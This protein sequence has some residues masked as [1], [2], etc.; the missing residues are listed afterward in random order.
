MAFKDY[1][2]DIANARK[3]KKAEDN[4]S[5]ASTSGFKDYSSE[6][7]RYHLSNTI[8]FDTFQTDLTSLSKTLGNIY[9]GWQNRDTMK[10]TLSSVQSMYDRL[11]KY[12]EYQ[13]KYGGTD[14]SELQ[15][16]YKSV[17][18]DWDALSNEYGR[19]KDASAYTKEKTKL[20]ELS[21]MTSKDIEPYLKDKKNK[22][23]Y[24]SS[25]GENILW[26]DLYDSAYL[27]EFT[28]EIKSNP[29]FLD[30]S[31]YK[32][33]D[34]KYEKT[35]NGY[36]VI[37]DEAAHTY[38][39]INGDEEAKGYELNVDTNMF[40]TSDS[41][42]NAYFTEDEKRIFN[43]IWETQGQEKA[44][45][46]V[47]LLDPEL[48]Q[49]RVDAERIFDAQ[50]AKESPIGSS[51]ATVIANVGNNAMALPFLAMDYAD[52]GSIDENSSLYSGR[53]AVNT[54]RGT[55]E[56]DIDN[57][58]GKFFYRHGM[59][60][61]DN[62]AAMAV[63][64][65]G[66]LGV[67]SS[68]IQKGIMS[69]GAVVDTVLD[70][71]S[72]GLSDEKALGLGMI[73][74]AAEWYFESKSFDALFD[75]KTLTESGWKYF[76]NNIKTELVGEL[77]TELTNDISDVLISQDFSKWKTDINSYIASGMTEKEALNKAFKEAGIRYLDV[78]AGTLFS[79]GVISGTPAVAGSVAQ[80]S[81]NKNMGQSIKS[82]ERVSDM[83]DLASNPEI[84]TAYEAYTRYANKG[85]NAENIKDAQLGSLY[86]RAKADAV[87]TLK[88]KK[89][90]AE[91]KTGAKQTLARLS[92][93][94]TENTV[95][96]E[97]KK[98]NVGEETKATKSG[99]AID[100]KD[101]KI[102]GDDASFVTEKGNISVEDATLTQKDA[103]FVVLARGIAQTDGEDAANLFVSQYDGKMDVHEYANS[104]NLTMAY[105]KNNFT[106]RTILNKKGKLSTEAVNA[107]Y[108]QTRI[109][110]D[111]ARQET[112]KKLNKAMADKMTYQ[113]FIDD[114][115]IDYEN[116]SA[117]GKVNWKD[118]DTRQKQAVTFIKGFAQASGMNLVLTHNPKSKVGG[119]YTVSGNTITIDIAKYNDYAGVLRET[120][121]PTMSHETTHWMKEKSP[122]LWRHLNEIVFTTLTEHYNSNTEQALKDKR[123]LLN[124]LGEKYS[125]DSLKERTITEKDL[126]K[127]EIIRAGKSE[128]V[129]REE[130]I[131]RACEDMLKM[132][133]QGRKIFKSLSESEQ[134][135]LYEK[136]KGIITDLINWVNDLLNS[137]ESTSTEARIMREYKEE[138][139]KASKI[140][141]EMLKK[142]IEANQSLEKSG[143][144]KH[145]S[146]DGGVLLQ[147]RS[148]NGN[149]VVW[150]EENILK[151][152]KGQ[153]VHQFIADF[154]AE[155]IGDVYTLIESGQKVYI[156][157][158]LPGEYTQSQYT[159]KV[160]AKNP[161]IIKAKNKATANIKEIIEIAT[162]R[163]WEKTEHPENKDAKYGM[164][165]Y[166]TWFG[167]PVYD[168]KGNTVRANI[169]KAE[170]VIRN[171][172][173]GRKYLYD[174]VDIKKDT[175]SSDWMSKKISSAA[176]F[177]AGQKNNVSNYSIPNP[178]EKV[179]TKITN[180]ELQ[181][182]QNVGLQ[183]DSET[184][185]VAP[186]VL[187]SER[188]WNESQYVQDRETAINAIVKA[189][190]VSKKD[191]ARYVDN[192]NSIARMIADDRA[193]L[194]YE[195]NIDENA[196]AIKPNSEYK[197][198]VD[199]STLCAKRLLFT[200]TF[201]AIQKMLP[202]T[203][204]NSEDI[205]SLRSMMMERGYEVACGICYVE[206]T[207]REL[208]PITA[209]F[210]ERY[211]LSQ[212][213]G[214]PITRINSSGKEV[215]L[216][217]TKDQMETTVDK[218]TDK[219]LADKNYTPTLAELNTTDIDLVKRDHPL[220]YE[221]YLN[222]MNARG[223]AK[224]KLLET[225][226]EY[227]GEIL[228]HFKS[229]T[230]VKSRNDAGGL[231]VQSF[232]DFE[233]AHLID[234]M[235]IVL[236]MS[237]VG[238]MSQAYTKVPAFADVFGNTGMKINLSLIA[239]DNGL[240]K[241][242]NLI[243]DDVEGMPHKEAF[244]LR[245]KYSKNVG[246]ILVGKN[247]AHI[248][249]ALADPRI[250]YV[251]PFHKSS[252]KESLYDAMGLTGYDDYT[253]TQ[254]EKP[255]DKERKIK[256]FQP[257]EYWD[258]T[259]SGEENA[260]TYLKMCADDVRIPKFP[261]FQNCEGYWKLLIDFKMYDNDGVGSPQMTVKPDFSMDEANA[262]MNSYEGGHRAY[263]IAQDVVDDFVKNY[264]GRDDILHSDR[265][266]EGN[267]LTTDQAQF[268]KNSKARDT[269]G[270]LL[271]L[272]HGT[273][274]A[275]FTVFNTSY[276]KYGGNWFTTSRVDADSYAGNYKHK[277]FNP[278]EKDDIHA[279]VGGN[280]T[281]NSEMRFDSAE[282]LA[283]FKKDNPNAENYLTDAEIEEQL[284]NASENG[285]WDEYDRLEN[286]QHSSERK[287][288]ERAYSRYEWEHSRY[289]TIGELFEN[290]DMFSLN[291]VL[292]AYD[293]FDSNNGASDALADGATKE[294]LID[295]LREF[296][297]ERAEDESIRGVSFKARLNP[298]ESGMIANYANNRTYACYVNAVTPYEINANGKTLHGGTLYSKIEQGMKDSSYDSVI[299]RN[300][301]V[302]AHEE[303][304]DVVI[305]KK[306]NQ[307][308]LT[309]N[310]KPTSHDDILFSER[311]QTSIFD[312][313][314]ETDRVNQ[315]NEK[316][317]D[318][319]EKLK[320]MLKLD[321]KVT[322]GRVLNEK[323]VNDAAKYL[324]K[325]SNSTYSL[326]KLTSELMDVY[327]YLHNNPDVVWSELYQR[328]IGIAD[329]VL[330]ESKPKTEVNHYYKQVLKEIR[331]TSISLSESQKKEAVNIFDKNWNRYFFNRVNITDKGIGIESQWQEWSS[332][333]PD[334]FK[335]DINDGDMIGE[336]YD[337]ISTL[338]DASET[339]IEYDAAEQ[340]MWLADEIYDRFAYVFPL[341]TTADKYNEKIK[342]LR[343]EYRNALRDLRNDYNE[344]LANQKIAD[345]IHYGK[346]LHSKEKEIARKKATIE[347]KNNLYQKLREKRDADVALAKQRGAERLDKYKENAVRKTVIQ[348]VLSTVTSLNKKLTT[349]SKDIHIPESLKPVV[350]NLINAIDFSSK[351][352]LDKGIPTKADA[353]MENRFNKAK[354]MAEEGITLKESV[355]NALELFE[356]AEKVANN[357]SDGTLDLSLVTLD[358]DLIDSIKS[359]VKGI[360][361]LEKSEGSKFAL[362]QMGLDHLKTLNAMVK[363]INHWATE[364]DKALASKHKERISTI[365]EGTIAECEPLGERQEY[366][367]AIEGFKKF[368]SWS[369]LL[370]VNA[371]KRLG[372]YG[373]KIFS[374]MQDAQDSLAFHQDEIIN[375]THE[376]FKGHDIK[377]WRED[378]KE[379]DL[380]LPNGEKKKVRMP[381][382]YVMSLYCVSKQ[383]DA[384]RHLYGIDEKGY[385]YE[386]NGGGMTIRAFKE[387][388]SLKVSK[389]IENTILS[390]GLINQITSVLTTEQMEIADK[391]QEFMNTK[392]SEWCDSVSMALYG[393][394]KFDIENYFP[395]SVTPTTIKVLDP[396]D[397]RQSVHF[398]SILNYG[399][400]KSRN[401]NAKQSI[402]ISDI[403]EV[404][405]NHMSMAAIYS[406]YALPIYDV[407]RW[408]N[409]KSKDLSGSEIG[410]NKSIQKAFGEGAT[411]Y[412]G[413]LISDL[414]GQHESSRLGF[415]SKIFQNTKIAMVGNS[416]SVTLL[417]PTAYLKAMVKIPTRHL[418]KSVLYIKDFGARKGVE[419]AKKYC[420]IALWKSQGNFDTDIS[421]N[422]SSKVLHDETLV[423]KLKEWSLLGAGWMD[424]R[425]WGVLWNACEF[426]VRAN[427]KDLKVGSEEFYETVGNKL[428]EVIY[429]TQVV[430]SPLTRS[431]LMRSPDTGAKMIT[432]FASEITVAYNMVNEALVDAKLD[433][434]RNGK[435]GAFKRN[436]KNIAMTLTAYT[437]TSA[438]S[439]IVATAISAFRDDEEKDFEEL[440][441]MYFTNF[442]ADWVLIGKIPYIKE[443]LNYAQGYSSTRVD[444]LW[445][446]SAAKAIKYW[447]KAFEGKEGS[448]GKAIK[449]TLKSL[450]YLSGVPGYNQYRDLMAT[451][452]MLGI[453]KA[454][455]FNEMIDDIF[456]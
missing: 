204:F 238:L 393:I 401:P 236:D 131:A 169:Y 91:Q 249:A 328:F 184:D 341:V 420:G 188:T 367:K 361:V 182:T 210:I 63:S 230:A 229:K 267:T 366:I 319:V 286:Y 256:N 262:I 19:Y 433:V 100:I 330:A 219:F 35:Y 436:A 82:N 274:S 377:K 104:F 68:A 431:D 84:G 309:D 32:K 173:D 45:E 370:P 381:V 47:K 129:S 272:Y 1:S 434:K 150:I 316:R 385:I 339:I 215:E 351:Q 163:R 254:N 246:T 333:Y 289:A 136:I 382:S 14:L 132:S 407:V 320:E 430:D 317:K 440:L 201:D 145:E 28:Q 302:G 336:L 133:E 116:T 59:N 240:D 278:N 151:E 18:D 379:F 70:A 152:N 185:S 301:R 355:Q 80:H 181:K 281:L 250:D 51:F 347:R 324:R 106:Y 260:K 162:N 345:D 231:R 443:A 203:V 375:F 125:E 124:R 441:K 313:M 374:F 416:I 251:I 37:D 334:I 189:I 410:V 81:Y 115:V 242:G 62:V 296:E 48:R 159:Q 161:N 211:K 233:V 220:V 54:I 359:L 41:G 180:D 448:G 200:G 43:S 348:S 142:S 128:A 86:T 314:G 352:M 155:H 114:A 147:T 141:D 392:G 391:L 168:S 27:K 21:G 318:A 119:S 435:E 55:V 88:S 24:T 6:I 279:S 282:D 179:K 363:S 58:V 156:G 285:E 387:K 75:S 335:A 305:I 343:Y 214:K 25:T 298:G 404:F 356:G 134:K 164:Y 414:N 172:S 292:R 395:I 102:K 293:A 362:Q 227:K 195:P 117:D 312:T 429:E 454:E 322:G 8:G 138:L 376:L 198:T 64:G 269:D 399:F 273:A 261:Q 388:K 20:K 326:E 268:F 346:K 426:E 154:I 213:T 265:D 327:S 212:K 208:G 38:N 321:K 378:I 337:I 354:S 450:S 67:A 368:F 207:R 456:D 148:V 329:S 310:A 241:N 108:Q 397:K 74:G 34:V 307:A 340:R 190:G 76:L 437:L 5:S 257:S 157:E 365:S 338:Q 288:I 403:F 42:K 171:A 140:W 110:A 98:L 266:S 342:R 222:F 422:V 73:S 186:D 235:Q 95:K 176:D 331:N 36:M 304:G 166:D 291:D 411:T 239:K 99:V 139:E 290:P 364:A 83:F 10:S 408:F 193:R 315:D 344:R 216:T 275:G 224:P 373:E 79:T 46:Y 428:R 112:I 199:M 389:D 85:I 297:S 245:D 78:A 60:T 394:K 31:A 271:V 177:S 449:E 71:R 423:D 325:I 187:L 452:D 263:P 406:S 248:R 225:R 234:M 357:T 270:K 205:V 61:A 121:I 349:N 453:L 3:K 209:E 371:F 283:K 413:R 306:S 247:D 113:G 33:K 105:S 380:M 415:I 17:L 438:V 284:R 103:E 303:I 87:E 311:D 226:T 442:L 287:S 427:R 11:G 445:F 194:D 455:D 191:A 22:I 255:F 405:A 23:A 49:R 409:Y 149:E 417:Q 400:T 118:L 126:L 243:F 90:T 294:D 425:T 451:L 53:R 332:L 206:S 384:K 390:E 175:V 52:D 16:A 144:F 432:M 418:L 111:K 143:K 92:V 192:I 50:M 40:G 122:E 137:Y 96:K 158:D 244:R 280:F 237:R 386:N 130:I 217:K 94:D 15:T 146:A 107:I 13:K 7:D 412:I 232:S 109:K 252:W 93:V 72:R 259:K 135:T 447:A 264:E 396:Q 183:I 424:E 65:F 174:I 299:V 123:N 160:L 77:G 178:D 29:N 30:S 419:K 153:P 101:L 4:K 66:K 258:Y 350:T 228:K 300:A 360:D 39:Y 2:N 446:D 323:Q 97:A 120:I 253:D 197:W 167:F 69:S 276:G 44:L 444:T 398:F 170:L 383:E 439:Q 127:A 402:E 12:Q 89:T 308:K 277:L 358:A 295:S 372:K 421:K 202:N 369:N 26:Q 56:S 221:A 218:S 57:D 223:Q 165:R 353:D 196:S 9:N